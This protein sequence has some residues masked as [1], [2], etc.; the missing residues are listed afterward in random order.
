MGTRR[1][2]LDNGIEITCTYCFGKED[3]WV[4]VPQVLTSESVEVVA[5]FSLLVCVPRL[6]SDGVVFPLT[7]EAFDRQYGLKV[8]DA[9]NGLEYEAPVSK[10]DVAGR[11]NYH[12]ATEDAVY[13][14]IAPVHH[15]ANEP[16]NEI[17]IPSYTRYAWTT[18]VTAKDIHTCYSE[19]VYSQGEPFFRGTYAPPELEFQSA[20]IVGLGIDGEDNIHVAQLIE[21]GEGSGYWLI[22]DK[23]GVALGVLFGTESNAAT[24]ADTVEGSFS[25]IWKNESK[26]RWWVEFHSTNCFSLNEHGLMPASLNISRR[27]SSSR[28]G[29][30]K[31]W[32]YDNGTWKQYGTSVPAILEFKGLQYEDSLKKTEYEHYPSGEINGLFIGKPVTIDHKALSWSG[33]Q[34]LHR[35]KLLKAYQA[36]DWAVTFIQSDNWGQD[37]SYIDIHISGNKDK[38][39]N[40]CIGTLS[41]SSTLP[42]TLSTIVQFSHYRLDISNKCVPDQSAKLVT[43]EITVTS[44]LGEYVFPAG[45]TTKSGSWVSISEWWAPGSWGVVLSR[46]ELSGNTKT[47]YYSSN[48]PVVDQ[49]QVYSTMCR[50]SSIQYRSDLSYVKSNNSTPIDYGYGTSSGY[51]HAGSYLLYSGDGI[52]YPC[53]SNYPAA[54][55]PIRCEDIEASGYNTAFFWYP[56]V[57]VQT[58]EWR[59]Y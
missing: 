44:S 14:I 11:G 16:N 48:S 57:Y 10:I 5:E 27:E 28:A 24:K 51:S 52:W 35:E 43:G 47:Q 53:N 8:K 37:G 15:L 40:L 45:Y 33:V 21:A 2:T 13:S 32:F 31:Q 6:A 29:G 56:I 3:I 19:Y 23:E 58:L 26:T 46:T 22:N 41:V 18:N 30:V 38:D 59:C 54:D 20:L 7:T 42:G 55:C 4:K 50:Y 49:G 36:T 1:V 25:E 9:E 34:G 17:L 12:L 39:G